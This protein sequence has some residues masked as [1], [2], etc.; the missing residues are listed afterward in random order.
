MSNV[1]LHSHIASASGEAVLKLRSDAVAIIAIA[2]EGRPLP[3]VVNGVAV[4]GRAA[5]AVN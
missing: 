4:P 3:N 1:I 2:S 5:V